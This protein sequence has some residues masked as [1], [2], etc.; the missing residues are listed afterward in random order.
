MEKRMKLINLVGGAIFSIGIILSLLLGG[1]TVWGDLE[2][3]LFTS[4]LRA[5]A[6]LK[7][8]QCPVM[9]TPQETS[10]ISVVLKNPSEK[11]LERFLI[12]SIS[13]GYS[14]L[15]R[16]IRTKLDIAPGAKQEVRW[17][18]TPDDAAFDQRVVL[19][20]VYVN[21]RYPY[22]SL[23]ANCGV[24]R[25]NMPLLTG[26]QLFLLTAGLALGC[27]IAGLALWELS[28]RRRPNANRHSVNA[29]YTLTAVMLIATVLGYLGIWVASLGFLVVAVLLIGSLFVRRV[30]GNA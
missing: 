15:V 5:D 3:S 7:T 12:A 27:A 26:N 24:V 29:L 18:I 6:A 11:Q 20:R 22:P 14:S 4:G 16:E 1:I 9:I 30:S 10:S 8:L 28:L 19:F 21:P 25:I 23:G 13:E 17:E 2:A